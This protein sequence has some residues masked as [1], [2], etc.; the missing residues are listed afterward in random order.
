MN[1]IFLDKILLV[2]NSLVFGFLGIL[3]VHVKFGINTNLSSFKRSEFVLKFFS[4]C[5]TREYPFYS[6]INNFSEILWAVS[7]T[8]LLFTFFVISK[9]KGYST[10]LRNLFIAS[11]ILVFLLMIDDL[12]RVTLIAQIYLGVP[13]LISYSL[14]GLLAILYI[15]SVSRYVGNRNFYLLVTSVGLLGLSSLFDLLP[16]NG[17]TVPVFLEEGTELIGLVNLC[18]YFLKLSVN[19]LDKLANEVTVGNLDKAC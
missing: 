19:E 15:V 13:K 10:R 1:T 3:A 2:T 8:A 12:F 6:Y 14:Y 16:L 17:Q 7:L 5:F 4:D 18:F 11:A 9:L